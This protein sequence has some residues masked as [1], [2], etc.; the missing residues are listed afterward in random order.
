M[1]RGLAIGVALGALAVGSTVAQE[2]QLPQ[3]LVWTSFDVGSSG[4]NQSIAIGKAL[5]DAYGLQLRVLATSTDQS[6][7]APAREGRVPFALS[8][9][10]VFYAF[11]G[12]L[13]YAS[14]D[15]GPQAF[16]ALSIVGGENC[17]DLGVAADAGIETIADVAGKRVGKV[18]GSEALQA[19]V[20]AFLAFGGL[21]EDDVQMVE[22]P[23]YAAAWQALTNGQ[24][25]AMTGVTTGGVIEQAAAGPRGL[26]WMTLDHDDEAAWARMQAV[27]PHFS[28][29]VATLGANISEDAPVECAG[30]PYPV[31][32]G[33]DRH[34]DDN[35]VY[36]LTKAI[37]AQVEIFRSAEPAASGWAAES[38]VFDWVVP[39][40]DGA[41]QYYTEAGL[42]TDEMQAHN[43][44]LRARQ[45]ILQQAWTQMEG[46]SGS[47]FA[48]QW[49]DV[50]AQ[51]LTDAGLPV[52]FE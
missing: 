46:V 12:V 7:L 49:M 42:W 32:I 39:Y 23:S 45:D 5:Q 36:N 28:K 35:V 1:L 43:D 2:V 29:R 37:D 4:Y 25:D 9:S 41:I 48:E 52:Y 20:R 16:G 27:N 21:T 13:S 47:D 30:V 18:I 51:A 26:T 17:A 3:N 19:N 6:R 44:D 40:A 10:D 8:G 50:R 15:W 33:Y 14:P 11:E 24:I 22:L 34:A 31:L 38:Q